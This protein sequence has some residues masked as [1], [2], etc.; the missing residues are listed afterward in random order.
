MASRAHTVRHRRF[1]QLIRQLREQAGYTREQANDHM[2]WHKSKLAKIETGRWSFLSAAEVRSLVTLYGVTEKREQDAYVQLVKEARQPGWWTQYS[3]L[4]GIASYASFEDEASLIQ[5]FEP[6]Y[7]PGLLQTE[8]YARALM[9]AVPTATPDETERR[10]AAR[11]ERHKLLERPDAPQFWAII[12]EA[13]IRRQPIDDGKIIRD[14]LLHL[15]EVISQYVTLLVIPFKAGLH[16]G[17][18]GSF[19]LLDFPNPDDNPIVFLETATDGLYLE[20][21]EDIERYRLMFRHLQAMA[22]GPPDSMQLLRE[23]AGM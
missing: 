8:D 7:I 19:A 9:E 6:L 5:T 3:D 13:A 11:V 17:I 15:A 20:T 21:P 23:A 4:S 16:P 12:D 2:E 22:L 14:Q 18:A 10:V 1:T